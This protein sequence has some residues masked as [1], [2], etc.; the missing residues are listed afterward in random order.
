MQKELLKD[1]RQIDINLFSLYLAKQKN[2]NSPHQL[3]PVLVSLLGE[4][5]FISLLLV[6]AGKHVY[7]PSLSTL[8]E[9]KIA[10]EIHEEINKLEKKNGTGRGLL[11]KR[12]SEKYKCDIKKIL[13]K[14][15]K[16]VNYK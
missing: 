4:K 8:F 12:F 6:M 11:I 13:K 16:V 14:I 10:L 1:Q 15:R 7:F 9:A 5:S 2:A 3:F